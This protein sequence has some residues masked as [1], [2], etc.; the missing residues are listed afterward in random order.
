MNYWMCSE[1][2]SVF[3]AETPAEVYPSCHVKCTFRNVTCYILECGG[4]D[5]LDRRLVAQ[6]VKESEI[7]LN[8]PIKRRS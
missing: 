5:H 7:G 1:C 6:R 8:N 3:E 4:P 2:N